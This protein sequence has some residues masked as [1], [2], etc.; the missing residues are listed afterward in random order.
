[1]AY[2]FE[3]DQDTLIQAVVHPK[4][5]VEWSQRRAWHG[6]TLTIQVRSELLND[7]TTV[8]LEVQSENGKA[9]DTFAA[10]TI[11]GN[12]LDKPYK[13]D[14]SAKNLPEDPHKFV[15]KATV[16]APVALNAQSEPLAVDLVVPLFSA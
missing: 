12:K 7:G 14:W 1:M 13:I 10:E 15:V 9:V 6:Q 8:K 16:T 5:H 2:D 11:N 3:G 4:L